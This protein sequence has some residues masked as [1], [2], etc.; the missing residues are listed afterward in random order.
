MHSPA[1]LGVLFLHE[2]LHQCILFFLRMYQTVDLATP[3]VLAISLM[4]LFCFWSLTIVCFTCMESSF[5]C[6]MRIQ[7]NSFQMQM[8]HLESTPDLLPA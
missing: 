2:A 3:N 8:A 5:D 7:S 4:D 6:M 1:I